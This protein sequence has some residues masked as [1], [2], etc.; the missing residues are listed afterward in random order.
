[1]IFIQNQNQNQNHHQMINV[2]NPYKDQ[3]LN[4]ENIAESYHGS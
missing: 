3:T 1:M 4:T 2:L